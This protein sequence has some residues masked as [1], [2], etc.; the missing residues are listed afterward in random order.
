MTNKQVKLWGTTAT[1]SHVRFYSAEAADGTVGHIVHSALLIILPCP[2]VQLFCDNSIGNC[3]HQ[4]GSITDM[5]KCLKWVLLYY[6]TLRAQRWLS[7]CISKTFLVL[8]LHVAY[9]CLVLLTNAA[10][11]RPCTR[12]LQV[13]ISN[14]TNTQIWC[15]FYGLTCWL[16]V[17]SWTELSTADSPGMFSYGKL[18]DRESRSDLFWTL[19]TNRKKKYIHEKCM[20]H[21][22]CTIQTILAGRLHNY[23]LGIMAS[24]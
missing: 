19:S 15:W 23:Y 4:Y 17:V 6:L 2:G 20:F 9:P 10:D 18:E 3:V 11:T 8:C 16:T 24:M 14:H 5:R 22:T 1:S 12:L 21:N 7:K 13:K